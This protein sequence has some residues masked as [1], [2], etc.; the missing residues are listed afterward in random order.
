MAY[1]IFSLND[2]VS[3]YI[4]SVSALK[5]L[6]SFILFMSSLRTVFSSAAVTLLSVWAVSS[7][8]IAFDNSYSNFA[9]DAYSFLASLLRL[10]FNF[11]SSAMWKRFYFLFACYLF[12]FF[13]IWILTSLPA[14]AALVTVVTYSLADV[15]S[16]LAFFRASVS[17][18]IFLY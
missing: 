4:R 17:S 5:F 18:N 2:W 15:T 13:S 14:S 8:I 11:S 1:Y 6:S 7:P 9:M 10:E 3:F 16:N 12:N